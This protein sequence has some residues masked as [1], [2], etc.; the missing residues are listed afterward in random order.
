MTERYLNKNILLICGV[1]ATV[2]GFLTE[3]IFRPLILHYEINDFAINGFA[4]NF[5]TAIGLSLFVAITTKKKPII[6]MAFVT[7]GILAYEIEQV[8]TD[9]TFDYA[10][11]IATLVGYGLSVLIVNITSKKSTDQALLQKV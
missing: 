10:D 9:M 5:F 1:I 8:W 4:P 6:S 7:L 11:I 2:M 3:L